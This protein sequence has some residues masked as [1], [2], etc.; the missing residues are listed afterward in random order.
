MPMPPSRRGM[1]LTLLVAGRSL[2][3]CASRAQG[4]KRA[5]ADYLVYGR[6]APGVVERLDALAEAHWSYMDRFADRLVA[7][8]P[9]LSPDGEAH[10]GSMHIVA[11]EDARA[12]RRFA[13]D[14]PYRRA[15]VY[16]DITISRY[17]D[18]LGGSMWDRPAAPGLEESTFLI[19]GWPAISVERGTVRAARD[20]ALAASGSWVF[21]GLLTSDDASQCTG[22]AAG[23][24]AGSRPAELALRRVMESLGQSRARVQTHR[25]QRG[26]RPSS[27]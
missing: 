23:V 8:G 25:W 11:V 22:I 3:G 24:D 4:R 9:T 1:L 6:D 15:G 18:L 27:S 13:E 16:A 2:F 12:A 7:R 19:A 17:I 10:T 5:L 20:A 14:E 21:L 26:G